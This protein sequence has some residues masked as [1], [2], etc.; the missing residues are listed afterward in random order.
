MNRIQR[1]QNSCIR[2]IYGIRKFQHVSHKFSEL[3]WLKM[4]YRFNVYMLCLYHKIL[5]FKSPP[6]LY[7]KI[8]F[9]SDVH[10]INVRYRGLITT[11]MHRT[12]LFERGFQYNIATLY[13]DLP[14]EMKFFKL[15]K[16]KNEIKKY[17]VNKQQ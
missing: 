11:P 9:R 8:T 2:F 14:S 1:V 7:N 10:N 17:Y 5:I 6:Y 13:N 16:F 4:Q 15:S 12:S 3:G